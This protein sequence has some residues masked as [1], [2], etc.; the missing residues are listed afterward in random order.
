MD[1][2]YIKE[3]FTLAKRGQG[4]TNPN[5][6]VGAVIV[7]NGKVI[8]RGYH[9]KFGFPHAEAEAISAAKESIKGAT[10]YTNLEPCSHHGKTPPCIDLIIKSGF[11]RVICSSRD[12]NP[13][14]NGQGIDQLKRSGIDVV[15]GTLE[16]ESH[17]LNEAFFTFH[18]KKRPFIAIKF[19]ASLDGKI[20]TR[21][22]DSQWISSEKARDYARNLRGQYQAILVGINTVIH[23]D[24]HL[25]TRKKNLRDPI[26]IILDSTLKIPI[27]SQAL[28]DQDIIIITTEKADKIKSEKFIEKGIEIIVFPGRQITVSELL[29]KFYQRRI[30]SILVEGGSEVLGSFVDAKLIDKV[31]AFHAPIIIGGKEA[32]NAVGGTGV[33]MIKDALHLK[34]IT[35]KKFDQTILTIGDI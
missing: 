20:A 6:V 2:K 27:N 3:T 15:V 18:E 32:K 24:P 29:K 12:P 30:I 1:E 9:K 14:V 23:D 8:G 5:P 16:K 10:L 22:G 13:K 31:Y 33:S 4:W 7:K 35:H 25:G 11:S 26:R 19:A 21:A 34:N 17:K 28:R